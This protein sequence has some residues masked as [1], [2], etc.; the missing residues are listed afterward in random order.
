MGMAIVGYDPLLDADELARR[1]V[2]PVS[3]DE[4]FETSDFITLH[5]PLTKVSRGLI[6]R[7]NLKK[8][9]QAC[10]LSAR[11]VAGLSTKKRYWRLWRLVRWPARRWT[12]SSRNHRD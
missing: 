11:R 3:L 5:V 9:N 1:G 12:S 4:L 2:R 7:E 8:M 6:G 10:E